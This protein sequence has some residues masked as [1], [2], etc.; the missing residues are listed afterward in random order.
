MNREKIWNKT[1]PFIFVKKKIS[2][3]TFIV[4]KI[5]SGKIFNFFFENIFPG[6]LRSWNFFLFSRDQDMN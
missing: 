3:L 6:L 4:L 2:T 5:F 1:A